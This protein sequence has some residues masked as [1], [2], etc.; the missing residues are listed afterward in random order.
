MAEFH[1]LATALAKHTYQEK[2]IHEGLASYAP[3]FEKIVALAEEDAVRGYLLF[4]RGKAI[5]YVFCQRYSKSLLYKI[6]GY[7]PD[8][9]KFSPGSVPLYLIIEKLTSELD[10]GHF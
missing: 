4:D 10:F 5:A 2:L 1:E 7:D 3:H 8:F 6:V 9:S